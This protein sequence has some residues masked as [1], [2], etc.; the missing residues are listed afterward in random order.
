MLL[1]RD[2]SFDIINTL[3]LLLSII[4]F[5]PHQKFCSYQQVTL[6]PSWTTSVVNII[7]INKIICELIW[8]ELDLRISVFYLSDRCCGELSM[9]FLCAELHRRF[10]SSCEWDLSSTF[11]TGN[12]TFYSSGVIMELPGRSVAT[13]TLWIPEKRKHYDH[14]TL[15]GCDLIWIFFTGVPLAYPATSWESSDQRASVRAR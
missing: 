6:L 14:F 15:P 11:I 7:S 2:A 1:T 4:Y 12:Q 3:D 8:K 10:R 13:A 5:T 9:R